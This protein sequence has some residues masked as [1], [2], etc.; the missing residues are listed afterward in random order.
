LPAWLAEKEERGGQSA[1][2]K[3]PAK[4]HDDGGGINRAIAALSLV[5]QFRIPRATARRA[6]Q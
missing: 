3:A 6:G 4:K 1:A 2:K 5:W